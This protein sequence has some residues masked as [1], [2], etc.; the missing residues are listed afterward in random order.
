MSEREIK[1][2]LKLLEKYRRSAKAAVD[3]TATHEPY[4]GSEGDSVV[5]LVTRWIQGYGSDVLGF[6]V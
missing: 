1:H 6:E 3:W 5:G 4:L 2:L